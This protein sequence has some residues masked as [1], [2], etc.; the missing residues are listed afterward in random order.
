M[1]GSEHC[2]FFVMRSLLSEWVKTF[3]F[4]R[5]LELLRC[6]SLYNP[7]SNAD[8]R[9]PDLK[10]WLALFMGAF[11]D[12]DLNISQSKIEDG[13]TFGC[14]PDLLALKK[15][16]KMLLYETR[17]KLYIDGKDSEGFSEIFQGKDSVLLAEQH[18]KSTRKKSLL[19]FSKL[20]MSIFACAS[21]Q[22]S[23]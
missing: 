1:K 10:H 14:I 15:C 21:A 16:L 12:R 22:H 8:Q 11:Q 3:C 9:N 2:I 7:S 20:S 19:F 17:I 13:S 6:G 4:L 23:G 5:A 18:L